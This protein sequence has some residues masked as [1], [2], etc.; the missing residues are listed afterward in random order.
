MNIDHPEFFINN[1]SYYFKTKAYVESSKPMTFKIYKEFWQKMTG[2]SFKD[3]SIKVSN[4]DE[5]EDDYIIAG[6]FTDNNVIEISYE[7]N[8]D[9]L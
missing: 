8:F 5:T 2:I 4:R 1:E 6:N 3:F 9:D 7:G